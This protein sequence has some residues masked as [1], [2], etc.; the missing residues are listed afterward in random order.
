MRTVQRGCTMLLGGTRDQPSAMWR[1]WSSLTMVEIGSLC[2]A[3]LFA[4]STTEVHGLEAF[5]KL[6]D[7]RQDYTTRKRGLVTGISPFF[8]A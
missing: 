7:S 5:M 3:F 2:R 4:A 6:L 1:A 8:T